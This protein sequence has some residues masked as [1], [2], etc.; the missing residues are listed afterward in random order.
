MGC[1]ALPEKGVNGQAAGSF[2]AGELKGDE[3]VGGC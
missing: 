2:V 1:S 3:Q